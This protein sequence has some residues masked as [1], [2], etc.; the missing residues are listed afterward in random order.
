MTTAD[1]NKFRKA[2]MN[3]LKDESVT[4]HI[5]KK[6]LFHPTVYGDL[7]PEQWAS[8]LDKAGKNWVGK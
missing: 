6:K 5:E 1:L 8:K 4:K 2:W 7:S 3:I